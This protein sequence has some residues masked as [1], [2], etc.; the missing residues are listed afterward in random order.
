MRSKLIALVLTASLAI[1]AAMLVAADKRSKDKKIN[2]ASEQLDE[3]Q[4]AAHALNRLT[5]GPRPGE[6]DR[7]AS[8]GV[9][10][11]IEQQLNPGKIDDRALDARLSGFR[12]LR[13]DSKELVQN[14]PPPQILKQIASGR[15]GLPRDEEKRA[16]YEAGVER[17]RNRQQ[18]KQEKGADDTQAAAGDDAAQAMTPEEKQ[19]RQQ[20]RRDARDRADELMGM[21]AD[22]RFKAILKMPAQERQLIVRGLDEQERMQLIDGMSAEQKE[23]LLAMA[24]PTQVVVN[25]LS[26]AKLLRAAYSERQIEEVISDFWFNHFNVFI[27]KGADRYLV[28]EYEREVIRP[29][30]LGK[31]SDLLLA[32]AKSPAMM[33]YLDNWQSVGPNSQ[34]AKFGRGEIGAGEMIGRRRGYGRRRGIYQPTPQQQQRIDK[35]KQRIPKGLNENYAREV[36]ELHTLGVNGGYTQKDVTELARVLSGWSIERPREGG[37]FKF[38]DRMHDPGDKRV[39][40]RTFKEHG[41]KEGEEALLMLA[42]HPST[43]KFISRKLAMRFVSD[44]PPQPLVDEMA[45]TFEKSDGD[46]KEVLRTM[47]RSREFWA[48]TT[49]RAKVKTPLEFVVSAV[50]ATS[51]DIQNAQPLVRFLQQSGMQPY[52]AQPPTGYSTKADAW[53]NSGALL[54]RLNF[55]LGLG[56]GKLPG[57][58]MDPQGLLGTRAPEDP[59]GVQASLENTLLAGEISKQTHDTIRKQMVDP[60]LTGVSLKMVP[61]GVIAGLILGSPEFQRR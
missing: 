18:T 31:F 43:A 34:A 49:Y 32:T 17:Y 15:R 47:F 21:D 1:P 9:A 12:T 4:R 56:V 39:L 20:M 50:R 42:R 19:Q 10:N 33:F 14:F 58:T 13:M 59:A 11:W 53:V 45:R 60:Q 57:V 38:N 16:V 48:P 51:A 37:K 27:N 44:D 54:A 29:H 28:T 24:N 8:M 41:E 2:A 3:R 46:I 5:F 25:E 6:V 35:A 40:G 36:M 23:T 30:A 52:G 61:P 22:A 55:A 7:V 26:Q